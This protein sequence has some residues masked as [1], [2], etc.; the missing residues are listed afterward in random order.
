MGRAEGRTAGDLLPKFRISTKVGYF[1]GRDGVEHSLDPARLHAAVEQAVKDLRREPDLVF[2]HNPE[3]SLRAAPH[4]RDVLAQAC[5]T[6][7]DAAGKGLCGTW[8]VASWGPSALQNLIDPTGPRPSVL[9]VRAGLLVGIGTLDATDALI[10]AWD[11]GDD[12]VWGMS[13][14]GGSASAPVWA[15]ID[16]RVFLRDTSRLSRVQ[17][18]FLAA[19]HLP[20]VASVAVGTDDPAHLGELIEALT[21]EVEERAIREYRRRLRDHCAISAPEAPR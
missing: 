6:L 20:R 5:S 15:R 4:G 2:L 21:G 1:P 16:P 18:A 3:H 8:G 9:M 14:F 12:A 10:K 7:H 13:P 17:A 19:H 11:L